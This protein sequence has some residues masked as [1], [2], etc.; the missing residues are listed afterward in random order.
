MSMRLQLFRW[1]TITGRFLNG[2]TEASC[3]RKTLQH[4]GTG[5]VFSKTQGKMIQAGFGV[6]VGQG[7]L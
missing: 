1:R 2:K 4:S 7:N 5:G 3:H 6:G